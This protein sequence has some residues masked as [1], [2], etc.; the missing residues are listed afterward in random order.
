MN[1]IIYYNID[2]WLG[3]AWHENGT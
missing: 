3:K 1:L 2:Y